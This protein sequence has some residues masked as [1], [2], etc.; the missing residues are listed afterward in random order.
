MRQTGAL[1][2]LNRLLSQKPCQTG[3]LAKRLLLMLIDIWLLAFIGV[4]LASGPSIVQY[5]SSDVCI[6]YTRSVR[7]EAASF[8]RPCGHRTNQRLLIGQKR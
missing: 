5:R 6:F 3:T 4:I 2:E 1:W 7:R 8:K